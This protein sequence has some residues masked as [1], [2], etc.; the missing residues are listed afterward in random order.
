MCKEI[1]AFG[2]ND[3]EKRKFHHHKNLILLEGVNIDNMVSSGEKYYKYFIG[4]ID[5]NYVT[6]Y[7]H[8][9]IA[10]MVK[11]NGCIF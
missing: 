8:M 5:D 9:L 1:I 10:V 7:A 11:L 6:K 3:I 2:N 4:Y